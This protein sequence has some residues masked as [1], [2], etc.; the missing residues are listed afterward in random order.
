MGQ[1]VDFTSVTDGT[2]GGGT[3]DN[4]MSAGGLVF[5]I[6]AAGNWTAN[7]D[8]GRFNFSEDLSA[9][10]QLLDIRIS[11]ETGADLRFDSFRI[12]VASSPEVLGGWS[13]SVNVQNAGGETGN[14]PDDSIGGGPYSYTASVS[15]SAD[16]IRIYETYIP[17][18]TSSPEI[19]FW[20]DD[21]TYSTFIPEPIVTMS[22]GS[23]S[24][25]EGGSAVVDGGLTLSDSNSSTLASATVAITEG[26]QSGQDVL[27]FANDGSTMGNI[28]ASYNTTSGTLSLTSAGATAS[29]A[30]WQAALRAVTYQNTSEDPTTTDRTISFTVNDGSLDS[31]TVSKSVTVA[32]VNDAPTATNLTQTVSFTEDGGAVA[33]GDIVVADAEPGDTITTTLTLSNP[34]SGML[35]TG[36]FG[37]ATS[38]FNAGTGVWTVTGSNADV[39]AALAA[40]SFTPA[41]NWDQNT[42]ITTRVRDAANTGPADGTITLNATPVNDAPTATNLT[43][44][45]SIAEG[46]SAVALDDIVVTDVD[47][48]ETV[49]ATLTFSDSTAGSLSTGTYGSATSTYNAG[50]G[51]WSVTGSV[52]D[53]NAALAAVALSPSADNDQ[54]FTITTRIRDAAGTGPADGTITVDVTAVNDAPNVTVPSSINV[55]EDQA[56]AVTGISFSDVDAGSSSVTATFSV[57]GGT[58]A[59]SSGGGVTVGGTSSALTLTGTIADMNA[60]LAASNLMYQPG[61]N[62]TSN[63][64]LTASVNDGENTGSGGAQ[65][66]SGTLTLAITAVNDAPINS[67][68]GA[69]SVQQDGSLVFNSGNGNAISISDV[70]AGTGNIGVTLAATN[71]IFTLGSMAGLIFSSGDGTADATA[72]FSGSLASLNGALDGLTFMPAVGHIGSAGL[73]ISTDDGGNAGSGGNQSDT[74]AIAIDVQ[75]VAPTVQ[76]VNS[77]AAAGAYKPGD[78]IT[79]TVAFDQSVTVDTTGGTPSLLLETGATDREAIYVSGS[80]TNTLTFSYTVQNGDLSSDLDYQSTAAMALN[81]GTIQNGSGD[82][83]TLTLPTPGGASSIAGQKDIIVDGVAPAVT[84]VSVPANGTYSEGDTLDFTVNL[85][86]DATVN[87][88]PPRIAVNLATGGTVYADYLGGSGTS[89]LVFGMTVKDG[90]GDNDGIALGSSIDLNGGSIRD[91]AGNDITPSLNNVGATAGVL[92]DAIDPAVASVSVPADGNYGTG[93]VLSFTL[94][95]AEP[96]NFDQ[97]LGSPRLVLQLDTGG[98]VYA[99]YVSGDGTSALVFAYTVLAGDADTNGITV[100]GFDANGAVLQ[101]AAGNDFD[102]TLNGLPDISGVRVNAPTGGDPDPEPPIDDPVIPGGATIIEAEPSQDGS[103]VTVAGNPGSVDEVQ[104]AGNVILGEDLENAYLLGDGDYTVEGNDLDNVIYGN[105][106]NTTIIASGGN[107]TIDGG[108]GFN[109]VVFSG[110]SS[111]YSIEIVDGIA[112]VTNL[113]TGDVSRLANVQELTFSD[114][115]QPLFATS[116]IVLSGLYE[117]FLGRGLDGGGFD[118]WMEQSAGGAD[119]GSIAEGFL[120]SPEFAERTKDLTPEEFVS[121]LFNDFLDRD[122]DQ[123]GFDFWVD[124]INDGLG[125]GDVALEFVLAQEIGT[126]LDELMDRGGWLAV[127]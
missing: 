114:G 21:V 89:A 35:S 108:W 85:S 58:L 47:T 81:G 38:T 16:E 7:F 86:E 116:Q 27:V 52:A 102:P 96:V 60:F 46:G 50:T 75:S 83:A 106:G 25:V 49:T 63:V 51:V 26:L 88:G 90:H 74:D 53:V 87:G 120:N 11:V 28:A 61:L 36:T 55:T 103:P 121:S 54:D 15:G 100:T 92:I 48:G 105:V 30:Q 1:L 73:E 97:T 59:A 122:I 118:F 41:A 117:T 111:G 127:A 33:V 13:G 119:P 3:G 4:V 10:D 23:V 95:L 80:G 62:A 19:T 32:A 72:T 93:Q 68:P 6:T 22:S 84:S 24:F 67:V 110:S 17:D 82:D 9:P 20:L 37:S 12:S 113:L 29:L 107:D 71:G 78:V 124:A 44:S 8:D 65:T 5:T 56:T 91:A 57:P 39:N 45:K 112:E 123:A 126:R 18:T 31:N 115:T 70:D 125:Y 76:S 14:Y 101:D 64:T 79:L 66:D 34:L 43:Q 2:A 104:I 94:N 69:Q 77:T 40:V 99:D 42:T 109:S 98:T